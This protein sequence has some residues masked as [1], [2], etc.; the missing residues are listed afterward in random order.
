MESD[1]KKSFNFKYK[2][3]SYAFDLQNRSIKI[4]AEDEAN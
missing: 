4:T 2:N 1:K 3:I